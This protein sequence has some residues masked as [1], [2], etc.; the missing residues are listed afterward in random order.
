V[1]WA[2]T[3]LIVLEEYVIRNV[4]N[5]IILAACFGSITAAPIVEG[6]VDPQKL[7]DAVKKL[8]TSG[9]M[10]VSNGFSLKGG[11]KTV[12]LFSVGSNTNG[13]V[14]WESDMDVDCDG[15][16][17]PKCGSDPSYQGQLSCGERINATV[18]PFYVIPG[19]PS[20]PGPFN[21]PSR[22]IGFGQIAACIY[23]HEETGK[24]G[25]V[26][27]PFLDECGVPT[28]IGEGSYRTCELLDINP[29]PA[30]GG[31]EGGNTYIVFR[32][33]T[34]DIGSTKSDYE[35]HT[36]A[37]QIG[38]ARAKEFLGSVGILPEVSSQDQSLQDFTIG[39]RL[40]RIHAAG[41]HSVSIF[42]T[43]GRKIVGFNGTGA[44][45]YRLNQVQ[46]GVY[47]FTIITPTGALRGKVTAF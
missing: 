18:T 21:Y 37:I 22:G 47:F 29:D 35:N 7:L 14:F 24:L 30:V 1:R 6:D 46:S 20:N 8:M 39:E 16:G 28:L 19:E 33:P 3:F 38:T 44:Q 26:Y 4:L 43:N 2:K 27:C 45:S 34:G 9:N 36:K 32:G 12:D 17:D 15:V 13:V 11:S 40:V 5:L 10:V 41:N 25:V 23:K 42:G 31:S